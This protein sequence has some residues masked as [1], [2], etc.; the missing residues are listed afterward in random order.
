MII[1]QTADTMQ[2]LSNA[3]PTTQLRKVVQRD[4]ISIIKA[5]NVG[6]SGRSTIGDY[7]NRLE[8]WPR[9]RE[10]LNH[11]AD[12]RWFV[13]SSVLR[14]LF[15]IGME[16]PEQGIAPGETNAEDQ[17][18]RNADNYD[19]HQI[20]PTSSHQI[21]PAE[22]MTDAQTHPISRPSRINNSTYTAVHRHEVVP[23]RTGAD[24]ANGRKF[25]SRPNEKLLAK[26]M[27]LT[28]IPD[29]LTRP[30]ESDR[31]R[32]G[33][34]QNL[35]PFPT[36]A[37][38][39]HG[40]IE[41]LVRQTRILSEQEL[42]TDVVQD[43]G[44]TVPGT[45]DMTLDGS[46][47]ATHIGTGETDVN[48][49]PGQSDTREDPQNE[50]MFDGQHLGF[51]RKPFVKTHVSGKI[52]DVEGGSP[53]DGGSGTA[54]GMR[55]GRDGEDQ[56]IS[57]S[58][59]SMRKDG[60]RSAMLIPNPTSHF[61]PDR[62]D[63]DSYRDLP[64]RMDTDEHG[65]PISSVFRPRKWGDDLR[66]AVQGVAFLRSTDQSFVFN[67]RSQVD[68]CREVVNLNSNNYNHNALLDQQLPILSNRQ[69]LYPTRQPSAYAES[70]LRGW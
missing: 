68:K 63:D 19:P 69:Q 59:Q 70:A 18:D 55:G 53:D 8:T 23:R 67:Q 39:S 57:M 21:V 29:V 20:F 31:A 12:D 25:D 49:L 41:H 45:K 22:P 26:T 13:H 44:M 58:G 36:T 51:I 46:G 38:T 5:L 60:K 7:V 9:A 48:N 15:S 14:A 52:Q 50:T 66:R 33:Q 1:I 17:R 6:L 56:P 65:I 62:V 11:V 42:N 43:S 4:V 54:F 64:G 24:L 35:N 34:R 10:M 28:T 16:D 30:Q 3:T 47:A 40:P 32:K 61:R 37:A 2:R 27:T